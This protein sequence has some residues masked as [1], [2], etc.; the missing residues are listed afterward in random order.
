MTAVLSYAFRDF[1]PSEACG[2][3]PDGGLS[4]PL[5]H[6]KEPPA[7]LVALSASPGLPRGFFRH[8]PGSLGRV[9]AQGLTEERQINTVLIIFFFLKLSLV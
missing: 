5:R 2:S 4:R 7:P 3:L 9:V 6:M 1:A 8:L